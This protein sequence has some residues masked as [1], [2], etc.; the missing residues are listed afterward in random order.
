MEEPQQDCSCKSTSTNVPAKQFRILK[1]VQG[2][3]LAMWTRATSALGRA[4]SPSSPFRVSWR[5]AGSLA[6]TSVSQPITARH[7]SSTRRCVGSA[8]ESVAP[9]LGARITSRAAPSTRNSPWA[10]PLFLSIYF[11]FL[12]AGST[13]RRNTGVKSLCWGFKLQG[14]TWSFV[15]LTSHFGPPVTTAPAGNADEV[16]QAELCRP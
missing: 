7:W 8:H 12:G 13:G 14:L 3:T 16:A 6:A 15:E 10:V 5:C 4:L 11:R 9:G 1:G 2:W